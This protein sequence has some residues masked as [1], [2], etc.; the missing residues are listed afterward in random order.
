MFALLSHR[1]YEHIFGNVE[2][3]DLDF[4]H[5]V[6]EHFG[7]KKLVELITMVHEQN[8]TVANAKQVMMAIIDGDERM[9]A[10][11]A[12]DQGFTGIDV[13]SDEVK[14]AVGEV[15]SDPNNAA[16]IEK[17][18][19]GNDR[20]IM[21]LVGKVMGAVNRRGDPVMIKSLI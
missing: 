20:P 14:E 4:Q 9:P 6:E 3:K 5:V 21:S 1:I 10:Q 13:T 7:H 12:A 15:I 8:I 11:I 17:I 16:I 18:L 2:K 19:G